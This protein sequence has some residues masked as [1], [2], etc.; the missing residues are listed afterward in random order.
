MAV[1]LPSVT[2]P[3]RLRCAWFAAAVTALTLVGC[4]AL[5]AAGQRSA[6]APM[7]TAAPTGSRIPRPVDD[8]QR[9]QPGTLV[10]SRDALLATGRAETAAALRTLVPW[11]H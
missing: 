3:H 1:V 11:M 4:A 8:S 10:I 9:A 6:A 2:R 5:P 7:R